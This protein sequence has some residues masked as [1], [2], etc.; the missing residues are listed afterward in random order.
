MYNSQRIKEA[1]LGVG[2]S[3]LPLSL[4][5]F[6]SPDSLRSLYATET[7]A[8]QAKGPYSWAVCLKEGPLQDLWLYLLIRAHKFFSEGA[9]KNCLGL[10][11]LG[12]APTKQIYKN[13][14]ST[15]HL[16]KK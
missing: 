12:M 10:P 9:D 3:F 15:T 14:K 8:T 2:V 6:Y 13:Y 4:P 11:P 1:R 16:L 5:L 7:V